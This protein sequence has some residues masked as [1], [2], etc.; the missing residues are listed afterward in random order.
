LGL[1]FRRFR[2]QRDENTPPPPEN[3]PHHHHPPSPAHPRYSCSIYR[4]I[5]TMAR[6]LRLRTAASTRRNDDKTD[7]DEPAT[8]TPAQYIHLRISADDAQRE[9]A[10]ERTRAEEREMMRERGEESE[11]GWGQW[12]GG[13]RVRAAWRAG[14][15]SKAGER[16]ERAPEQPSTA[17]SAARRTGARTWSPKNT[18]SGFMRPPGRAPLPP[19]GRA[20]LPPPDPAG[21]AGAREAELAEQRG[22]GG[23]RN[24]PSS[25]CDS[26]ASP[27]AR[28]SA[29]ASNKVGLSVSSLI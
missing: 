27:S 13:T 20:P 2:A 17:A 29:A 18:T 19:P 10:R 16:R 11:G 1:E 28:S 14:E 15:G 6:G 22:Q 3:T 24:S 8:N 9:G 25:V 23:T 21:P 5:L 4:P 26:S 12:G 7:R